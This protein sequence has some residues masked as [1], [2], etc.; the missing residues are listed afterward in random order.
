MWKVVWISLE[1]IGLM[2]VRFLKD[3]VRRVYD[4]FISEIPW[5][6]SGNKSKSY[7]YKTVIFFCWR[8]DQKLLIDVK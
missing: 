7:F 5:E 6:I 8:L 1:I 3:I 4:T 2:I